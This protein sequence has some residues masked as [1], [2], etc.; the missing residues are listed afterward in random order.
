M[1]NLSI[2]WELSS[3]MLLC[4]DASLKND[5]CTHPGIIGGLCIRCGQK[6]DDQS[7]VA[8]GYIHKVTLL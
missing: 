3:N 6:V 8:F 5:M 7:G 1:Y 2:F 4:A